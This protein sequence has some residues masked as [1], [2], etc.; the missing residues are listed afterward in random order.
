MDVPTARVWT[1]MI[2]KSWMAGVD[3]LGDAFDD[4]YRAQRIVIIKGLVREYAD[5]IVDSDSDRMDEISKTLETITVSK[6]PFEMFNY[7]SGP[8]RVQVHRDFRGRFSAFLG[9][10]PSDVVPTERTAV[11]N[12]GDVAATRDVVSHIQNQFAATTGDVAMQRQRGQATSGK[13][14]AINRMQDELTEL[15]GDTPDVVIVL[16]DVNPTNPDLAG[17]QRFLELN[18][19]VSMDTATGGLGALPGNPEAKQRMSFGVKDTAN[20]ETRARFDTFSTLLNSG[21]RPDVAAA[22]AQTGDMGAAGEVGNALLQYTGQKPNTNAERATRNFTT[23]QRLGEYMTGSQ[24]PQLQMVGRGLKTTGRVGN[25]LA[26]NDAFMQATERANYRFRG[27]R[28]NLPKEYSDALTGGGAQAHAALL[29]SFENPNLNKQNWQAG[30][31]NIE[32]WLDAQNKVSDRDKK[33]ATAVTASIPLQVMASSIVNTPEG[34]SPRNFV[35]RYTR[36]LAAASLIDSLPKDPRAVELGQKAGFGVPSSGI[37]IRADGQAKEMYHG[38]GEDHYLPFSAKALGELRDGQYVRTRNTGG[39]TPEDITTLVASGGRKATVLSTNGMF[40]IELKPDVTLEGRMRSPEVAA[41]G[42]RYER[43]LDQVANSGMYVRN[44]PAATRATLQAEAIRISGEQPGGTGY[45]TRYKALEA[46]AY[47]DAATVTAG[48]IDTLRTEIAGMG[49]KA[50]SAQQKAALEDG[51][52]QERFEQLKAEKV[53]KVRLNG[54][55]YALALE[56]LRLQYPSIIRRVEH[57]SLRDFVDNR[58]LRDAVGTDKMALLN[59]PGARDEGLVKPGETTTK[60]K[61]WSTPRPINLGPAAPPAPPAPEPPPVTT[62]AGGGATA[63]AGAA[64]TPPPA[65]YAARMTNMQSKRQSALDTEMDAAKNSM[66]AH[67][68]EVNPLIAMTMGNY[69]QPADVVDLLSVSGTADLGQYRHDAGTRTHPARFFLAGPDVI[70]QSIKDN[71]GIALTLATSLAFGNAMQ[72]S[73]FD[74]TPDLSDARKTMDDIASH[75][76]ATAPLINTSPLALG[77]AQK[78]GFWV[79]PDVAAKI[80]DT[81]VID[82][83][84]VATAVDAEAYD[85]TLPEGKAR[86]RARDAMNEALKGQLKIGAAAGGGHQSR[87]GYDI[88][89]NVSD[90]S[91]LGLQ[92]LQTDLLTNVNAMTI[93]EDKTGDRAKFADA[94]MGFEGSFDNAAALDAAKQ[95]LNTAIQGVIGSEYALKTLGRGDVGPKGPTGFRKSDE[96][97][98]REMLEQYL[99]QVRPQQEWQRPWV[100]NR[101]QQR[102]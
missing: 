22:M 76:M 14:R 89:Q 61:A 59:R 8:K 47:N 5:A 1:D 31:G 72:S 11:R 80:P 52:F 42:E 41:M 71:Q 62:G 96:D 77:D 44:L 73:A 93:H 10:E 21:I 26:G 4:L 34:V 87:Y 98:L 46:K 74:G 79:P 13:V 3:A 57:E 86:K 17:Q 56:T 43:I 16:E 102:L 81:G 45:N 100:G 15:F 29:S 51:I 67:G 7:Q 37:I 63:G 39:L 6:A 95:T 97:P 70:Q 30:L 69:T 101:V 54:E 65:S 99:L 78:P 91:L 58:G 83:D 38:V 20:K 90:L 18:K 55:G 12:R 85:T 92:A 68:F 33:G 82:A 94:V 23:A 36:D 84:A 25:K 19:P 49:V 64:P 66:V 35:D 53:R 9:G 60:P 28:D 32:R 50:A 88:A 27:M 48:E 24:I 40:H 2:G 75:T